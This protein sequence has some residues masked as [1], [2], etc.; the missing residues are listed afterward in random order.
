MAPLLTSTPHSRTSDRKQT[1]MTSLVDL[2]PLE[3]NVTIRGKS[4]AVRGVNAHDIF[5]LLQDY[6]ELRL[7]IAGKRTEGDLALSLIQGIPGSIG[8]I[9]AA[10]TG[11]GGEPEHIAAAQRL[12]IGEQTELLVAAIELTFPQGVS[13]FLDSLVK[14]ADQAGVRG[15]AAGTKLPEAS[16]SALPTDTPQ[17]SPGSTPQ[18]NSEL[19]GKSSSETEQPSA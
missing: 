9:I 12:T 3:K 16:S 1:T 17:T 11:H 8:S 13:S 6:P 14:L 15:W 7:V 2:G 18:D 10:A 5:G 4:I 19:G